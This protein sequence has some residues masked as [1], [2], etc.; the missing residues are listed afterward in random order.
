MASKTIYGVKG[1]ERA[2]EL[3]GDARL[4]ESWIYYHP[5]DGRPFRHLSTDESNIISE[6]PFLKL[7]PNEEFDEYYSGHNGWD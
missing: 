4:A 6:P 3:F 7:K 5:T 1:L 2:R